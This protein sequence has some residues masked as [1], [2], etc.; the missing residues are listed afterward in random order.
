MVS[1]HD[2]ERVEVRADKV[3]VVLF[4]SQLLSFAYISS[5]QKAIYRLFC[6]VQ[7]EAALSRAR[8]LRHDTQTYR[9]MT[10]S[11]A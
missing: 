9:Q 2:R 8:R 1:K 7:N 4:R 6:I 5:A 11:E 3:L 10:L